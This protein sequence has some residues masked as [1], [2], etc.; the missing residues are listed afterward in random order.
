MVECLKTY[1][2]DNKGWIEN[3]TY[4]KPSEVLIFNVRM[5]DDETNEVDRDIYELATSNAG[6]RKIRDFLNSLDLEGD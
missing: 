1:E 2:S 3:I 6:I 5:K 4:S